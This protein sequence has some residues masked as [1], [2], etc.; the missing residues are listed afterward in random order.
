MK[1]SA[2]IIL[3]LVLMVSCS[4]VQ[5]IVDE[6]SASMKTKENGQAVESTERT[7]EEP[8]QASL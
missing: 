1:R 2:I 3:T 4:S 8:T 7:I 6:I 5:E